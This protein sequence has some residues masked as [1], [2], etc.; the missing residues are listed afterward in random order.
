MCMQTL[1]NQTFAAM[2]LLVWAITIPVGPLL[3]FTYK[4]TK[5]FAQYTNRNIRSIGPD[6]QLRI[7]ACTYDSHNSSGIINLL[8]ASNP[9]RQ[10][11]IHIFAV[12]LVELI[13]HTS[14]MLIV[15][16][17]CKSNNERSNHGGGPISST[18]YSNSNSNPFEFYGKQRENF[19]V[20]A[21]TVVSAYATMHEDICNLAED[22]SITLVIVPFHK[23]STIDGAMEESDPA[24]RVVNRNVIDNAKCS[25]GVFVDRGLGIS[26]IFNSNIGSHTS[27][28]GVSYHHF[29]VFFIGGADDREALAYA[30]RMAGHPRV[31]LTVIRFI[32]SPEA[33]LDDAEKSNEILEAM[34]NTGRQKQLD[35]LFV[36]GFKVHTMDNSSIELVEEVVSSWEET[37]D[38]IKS[39]EGECD[40]YIMGR[41][42][43]SSS[44][45]TMTSV[46]DSD[47]DELGTLAD[48]LVSSSFFMVNTSILI[49]QQGAAVD[50]RQDASDDQEM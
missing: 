20:Q 19:Y 43:G 24:L 27:S 34:A 41:R 38:V 1:D 42:H 13:G 10:S 37:L 26:Q 5:R 29:A 36:D 18:R 47:S 49:V 31:D 6:T 4:T 44:T 22:E 45:S 21:L 33:C 30:K 3:A 2:T 16:D 14:A 9:T 28:D 7:L 40:L 15:N 46:L 11:P 23:Q 39:I 8:E 48:A 12:Q 50:D 17:A 35:D 32:L 25:V